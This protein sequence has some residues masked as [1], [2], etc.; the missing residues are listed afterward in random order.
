MSTTIASSNSTAAKGGALAALADLCSHGL[1]DGAESRV[2]VL[3]VGNVAKTEQQRSSSK[4]IV[5]RNASS[6]NKLVTS[7]PSA[8]QHDM[9]SEILSA[10]ISLT[11][12]SKSANKMPTP[13]AEVTCAPAHPPCEPCAIRRNQNISPPLVVY[14][15]T[16]PIH[17]TATNEPVSIL[18]LPPTM[19][20]VLSPTERARL[21]AEFQENIRF[22]EYQVNT[23]TQ[24]LQ[25]VQR[26]VSEHGH[27]MIPSDYPPNQKLAK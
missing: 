13:T 23:W 4:D 6:M 2:K 10:S 26:F 11:I 24:R 20:T 22:R 1:R 25:Q 15:H 9:I 17:P 18:R 21:E 5:T 12:L 14:S 27:C 19:P 3:L 16:G 8:D 7:P